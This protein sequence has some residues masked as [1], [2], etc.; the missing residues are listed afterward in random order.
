MSC[1]HTHCLVPTREVAP[2]ILFLRTAT[3]GSM[4]DTSQMISHID[5]IPN[6]TLISILNEVVLLQMPEDTSTPDIHSL[7]LVSKRFSAMATPLLYHT[8][9]HRHLTRPSLIRTLALDPNAAQAVRKVKFEVFDSTGPVMLPLRL[10]PL[11][12]LRPCTAIESLSVELSPEIEDEDQIEEFVE[13][14]TRQTATAFPDLLS[15]LDFLSQLK[16]LRLTFGENPFAADVLNAADAGNQ[17]VIDVANYWRKACHRLQTFETRL[18]DMGIWQFAR[19]RVGQIGPRKNGF[20]ITSLFYLA[21]QLAATF[22][23][24]K[25]SELPDPRD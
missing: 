8:L 19:S 13:E 15:V 21:S 10:L 18:V 24:S 2:L 16:H 17:L 25:S 6:E 23:M 1:C 11:M 22:Q 5:K 20:S 9:E 14:F 12:T 3:P 4:A 7:T